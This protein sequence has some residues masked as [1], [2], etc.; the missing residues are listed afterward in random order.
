MR[1]TLAALILETSCSLDAPPNRTATLHFVL[2]SIGTFPFRAQRASRGAV[3]IIPGQS[4]RRFRQPTGE[5][6]K[7]PNER[8]DKRP[9]E[10][11][12]PVKNH[13]RR[14]A[15][16]T[17]LY[18]IPGCRP[19]GLAVRARNARPA[20]PRGRMRDRRPRKERAAG[21]SPREDAGS[22]VRFP[23]LPHL[24][25]EN[26]PFYVLPSYLLYISQILGFVYKFR[27]AGRG[28]RAENSCDFQKRRP[29][30]WKSPQN[31]L[32]NPEKREKKLDIRRPVR[33]N[34]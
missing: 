24:Y 18:H 31:R 13:R 11:Q 15:Q 32:K 29:G 34:N 28:K 22:P 9:N 10:R 20:R 19:G 5:P 4:G 2:F 25:A 26:H 27:R 7:G 1:S 23:E 14:F 12:G 21:T 33:Y 8:P 3:R 16:R 6:V 17:I 30:G